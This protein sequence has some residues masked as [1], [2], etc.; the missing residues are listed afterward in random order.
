M[1]PRKLPRSGDTGA[2]LSLRRVCGCLG[3]VRLGLALRWGYRKHLC[4]TGL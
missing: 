3:D 4:L 2:E 1:I